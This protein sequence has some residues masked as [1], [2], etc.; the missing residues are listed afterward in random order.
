MELFHTFLFTFV[1]ATIDTATAA[2]LYNPKI[3]TTSL[4]TFAAKENRIMDMWNEARESLKAPGMTKRSK[5]SKSRSETG[6]IRSHFP[7]HDSYWKA[8]E[9]YAL[10]HSNSQEA[11]L[12]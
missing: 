9:V 1:V 2:S 10:S 3:S 4:D 7:D 6:P 11:N 12:Y 5:R 8:L